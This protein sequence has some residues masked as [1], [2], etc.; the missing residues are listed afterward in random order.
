M[1]FS[2]KRNQ[3]CS[4]QLFI[5]GKTSLS[6]SSCPGEAGSLPSLHWALLVERLTVE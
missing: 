6:P 5:N 4:S 3:A 1:T 2:S